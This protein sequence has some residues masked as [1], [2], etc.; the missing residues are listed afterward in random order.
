MTQTC[1]YDNK[2]TDDRKNRIYK[3]T[4]TLS[5]FNVDVP[6]N[7]PCDAMPDPHIVHRLQRHVERLVSPEAQVNVDLPFSGGRTEWSIHVKL[8]YRAGKPSLIKTADN[9]GA[10]ILSRAASCARIVDDWAAEVQANIELL[11][12]RKQVEHVINEMA[13]EA[14]DKAKTNLDAD[15]RIRAIIEEVRAES[16]RLATEAMAK[17]EAEGLKYTD[18]STE[19]PKIVAAASA[20]AIERAGS[21]SHVVFGSRRRRTV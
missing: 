5:I 19:D 10:Q 1:I 4:V 16:I 21:D 6:N 3:R 7:I 11:A 18:G 14:A 9:A 20:E 17:C 2:R 13:K 12:V 15:A 8:T